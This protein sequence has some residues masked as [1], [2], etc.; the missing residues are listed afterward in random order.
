MRPAVDPAHLS[1]TGW[2][3]SRTKII[4]K[5]AKYGFTTW[6]EQADPAVP[7]VRLG[8]RCLRRR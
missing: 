3:D 6:P 8:H 2:P 4:A 1:P 7:A 5:L